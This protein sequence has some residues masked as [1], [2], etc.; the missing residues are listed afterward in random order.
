MRKEHIK[1][2]W[3]NQTQIENAY[4]AKWRKEKLEKQRRDLD[5]W[6][7]S[8]CNISMHTKNQMNRLEKEEKEQLERMKMHHLKSMR[9]SMENKIML[10]VMEIDSQRWPTLSNLNE[11][12]NEN[13]ILPQ[14]ILNYDEYY[15]KLQNLAFFSE[16]GDHESM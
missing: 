9:R 8:I 13:V 11:K 15:T 12:I 1:A 7:T 6:R 14:T 10:D 5:R 4:L 2:H 16:Q 3:E